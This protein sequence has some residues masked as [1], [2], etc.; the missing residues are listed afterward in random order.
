M[1]RP[2]RPAR[3]PHGYRDIFISVMMR[4]F[5]FLVILLAVLADACSSAPSVSCTNDTACQTGQY[6]R[7]FS[8]VCPNAYSNFTVT[9]GTCHRDCSLG[10]CACVD[11]T[12]CRAWEQ[13]SQGACVPGKPTSCPAEPFTC[14]E[15]CTLSL[16]TDQVCS[17][18]CRC[19]V[20]PAGDGGPG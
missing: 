3:L 2:V 7:G 14:P 9:P 13:C 15:G 6:C 8:H 4:P 16:A 1:P 18:T 20:C 19:S 5:L 11:D 12:D 17:S 10:S